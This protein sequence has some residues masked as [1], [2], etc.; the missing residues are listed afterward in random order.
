MDSRVKDPDGALY[1][2][3]TDSD[4]KLTCTLIRNFNTFLM[5]CAIWRKI[6]QRVQTC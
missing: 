1:N 6:G 2:L 4:E 3:I 5:I